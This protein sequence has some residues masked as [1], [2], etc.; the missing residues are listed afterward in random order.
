MHKLK[1]LPL[2]Y[3]TLR[4]NSEKIEEQFQRNFS[5][6]SLRLIRI[7]LLLACSLYALFGILDTWMVPESIKVVWGIRSIEVVILLY[8]YFLSFRSFFKKNLH[9]FLS[10]LT[11][12]LGTGIISMVLVSKSE[13]GY[14]YYAGL[15]LVI[16]FANGLIRLRFV[17][18]TITTFLI[19]IAYLLIAWGVKNTPGTLVINNSFFLFSTIIIGMFINYSLEYYMRGN[20]WQRKMLSRQDKLLKSEYH[21]K[22]KELE[23]VRQLQLSILFSE[24]PEHP[25]IELA[26]SIKTAVEVGG[27]YY[28][29]HIDENKRFTFAIGD[30]TGHGAQAGALVTASKILFSCWSDNEDILTFINNTS[31]AIKQMGLPQLFMAMVAGRI[32]ENKLELAGAGLPPAL[33]HRSDSRAIEE[34]PLK[35]FP[36][37]C[38]A[39]YSY[40]KMCVELRRGDSL[41]FMTD[42]FPELFNPEKEML[43]IEKIKQA[44]CEV[45]NKRPSEI[46]EQLNFVV[47]N[48]SNGYPIK[49]DITFLVFKVKDNFIINT[50]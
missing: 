41:I 12:V 8:M 17:Y 15:M 5:K 7:A 6:E 31:R 48:W 47:K 29:Y 50:N 10:L 14:F 32:V 3:L 39:N 38:V 4:F 28:D 18:A 19:A 25:T 20:F 1:A 21:R 40:K 36:L 45:V 13:E 27:D 16:Q 22:T 43:G 2:N 34:I 37:G 49:D 30:A 24:L 23:N 26:V 35:G 44:F 42:G 46:V 11:F 9:F 33:I